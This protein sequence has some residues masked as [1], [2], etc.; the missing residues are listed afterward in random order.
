MVEL[1]GA[2]QPIQPQPLLQAGCPPAD[3]GPTA[4]SMALGTAWAGGTKG[5]TLPREVVSRMGA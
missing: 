2:L 5:F 4:P 3:Q 1:E